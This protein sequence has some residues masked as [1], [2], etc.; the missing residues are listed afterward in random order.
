MLGHFVVRQGFV[1]LTKFKMHVED[2][3]V[4]VLDERSRRDKKFLFSLQHYNVQTGSGAYSAAIQ[5]VRGGGI[6]FP[7]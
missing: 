3:I 4:A 7:R 5:L 1:I 6:F 2:A